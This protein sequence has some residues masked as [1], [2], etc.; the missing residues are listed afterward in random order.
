MR[1]ECGM[2]GA[3]KWSMKNMMTMMNVSWEQ[4]LFIT[5]VVDRIML[6]SD[7]VSF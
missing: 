7:A 1:G 5:L 4:A 2:N 3:Q 6:R